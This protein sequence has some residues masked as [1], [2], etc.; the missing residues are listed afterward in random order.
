MF[1]RGGDRVLSSARGRFPASWGQPEELSDL[2]TDLR[3]GGLEGNGHAWRYGD[4][5]LE[6]LDGQGERVVERRCGR[7]LRRDVQGPSPDDVCRVALEP[8][9]RSGRHAAR[10]LNEPQGRCSLA[11]SRGNCDC[12][13]PHGSRPRG[14][15]AGGTA[16]YLGGRR[17]H[18]FKLSRGALAKG[19]DVR[20]ER[21]AI[22]VTRGE[23]GGSGWRRTESASAAR[24][25]CNKLPVRRDREDSR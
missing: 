19:Y 22:D 8:S 16:G 1:G 7:C 15:P 3:Y 18:D 11:G 14:N 4:D 13:L 5:G 10:R 24:L 25:N 6:A 17:R 12:T 20:S 2:L 23:R 9:D 21:A